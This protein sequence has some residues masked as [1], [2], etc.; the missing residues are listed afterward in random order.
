MAITGLSKLETS[1]YISEKDPCENEEK[2]AT[3][4][5]LGVLD[6]ETLGALKDS[7]QTMELVEGKQ[8]MV[9][10]TSSMLVKA[11]RA[12]LKGWRNFKD[13]TGKDIM[14]KLEEGYLFDKPLKLVSKDTIDK[15]PFD[16]V[17]ELGRAIVDKNSRLDAKLL[18]NSETQ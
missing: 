1:E 2:G 18:K 4:F 17:I 13:E 6:K 14:F 3:I 9:L 15:M 12:G 5:I 10:N 7:A 8:S 16:L 11:C